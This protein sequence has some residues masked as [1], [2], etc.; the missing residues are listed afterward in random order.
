MLGKL[1]QS[2]ISI[3]ILS[4]LEERLTTL[5]QVKSH[6]RYIPPS[7]DTYLHKSTSQALR[8][9]NI[10]GWQNFLKG[11]ISKHW[12]I[13]QDA[14][15]PPSSSISK[16]QQWDIDLTASVLDMYK[17]IWDDRN[18]FVHG[19]SLKEAQHKKREYLE[20]QIA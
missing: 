13:A 6:Q 1:T 11:Y 7:R 16:H 10:L 9:Q 17:H 14:A 20:K 3:H 18:L 2:N 5:L 15:T 4:I 12:T 19:A 8:S